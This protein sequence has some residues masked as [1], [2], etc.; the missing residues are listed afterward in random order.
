MQYSEGP[1]CDDGRPFGESRFPCVSG[2]WAGSTARPRG[3]ARARRFSG[4][5][6]PVL[7]DAACAVPEALAAAAV[8][9]AGAGVAGHPLPCGSKGGGW[10]RHGRRQGMGVVGASPSV[11]H[12]RTGAG[13]GAAVLREAFPGLTMPAADMA[14]KEDVTQVGRALAVYKARMEARRER[15]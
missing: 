1:A 15:Q 13:S 8:A 4:R 5:T 14:R 11:R 7:G 2:G 6:L 9:Y 12:R 10:G 3:V